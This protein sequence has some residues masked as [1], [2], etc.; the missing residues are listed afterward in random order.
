MGNPTPAPAEALSREQLEALKGHTPGPWEV[1]PKMK[2][3]EW[4]VSVPIEG[5]LLRLGLFADGV[6]SNNPEADARLIGAA[7]DLL[8]TALAALAR[9][10][11][12]EAERDRLLRSDRFLG[13]P[14]IH[15]TLEEAQAAVE[16]RRA[17]QRQRRER[18]EEGDKHRRLSP[19]V[20]DKETLQ[21]GIEQTAL[22]Q[23]RAA[24]SSVAA[25]QVQPIHADMVEKVRGFY[26]QFFEIGGAGE[27][28]VL[29]AEHCRE[30]VQLLSAQAH[31]EEVRHGG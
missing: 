12:A 1:F 31:A 24:M 13:E 8:N 14:T 20:R 9:A 30:L 6:P 19:Y 7:P 5:T 11:A 23:T 25:P 2:Y 27:G 29:T 18:K 15:K 10:E 21:R 16:V 22:A 3:N 17:A 28:T 26:L 4:H